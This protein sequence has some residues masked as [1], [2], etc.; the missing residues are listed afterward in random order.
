VAMARRGSF[1][2]VNIYADLVVGGIFWLRKG[3]VAFKMM[4]GEI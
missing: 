3:F 1:V 2:L 4:N